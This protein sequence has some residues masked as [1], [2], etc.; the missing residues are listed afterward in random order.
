MTRVSVIGAGWYAAQSHIPALAAI[1]GVELDGVCRLGAAELE[2]V[3]RHFGF[4]H[5]SEDAREILARR[6]DAVVVASPHHLHHEHAAAALDAGAHVL[7]EKPMTLDPAAAWDLVARARRA[8]RHLLVANGHHFLPGIAELR[9]WI[10]AGAVGR[11]EHAACD[12]VSGTRAVFEGEV[13]LQR[14]S[15]T[16]FRPARATWQDPDRGG[17][18]VWGQ[19]SHAAALLLWL[20]GLV[21]ETVS[22]ATFGGAVDLGCSATLRCAGGAVASLSGAAAMPETSRA[23]M[24]VVV[25]GTGLPRSRWRA[26]IGS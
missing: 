12:F 22:G 26:G 14:W 11:G 8:G 20:T 16:F 13:G 9:D 7:V 24:R 17:G 1:P 3:R 25:S 19:M 21:P 18:F 23:L 10:A 5:A 2:R 15:E 4:A 6:P